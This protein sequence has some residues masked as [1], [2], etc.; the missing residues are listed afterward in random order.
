MKAEFAV[1]DLAAADAAADKVLAFAPTD[2]QALIFKGRIIVERARKSGSPADWKAARD[3]FRRAN[4]ADPDNAEALVLFYNGFVGAGETPP[5]VAM[6]G[7]LF[8]A[9]L[10]PRVPTLR[11]EAV[12]L[13]LRQNRLAEAVEMFRPVAFQPHSDEAS[14]ARAAQVLDAAN[15]GNPKEALRLLG[16]QR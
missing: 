7:L 9:D 10:V 6:K 1:R 14:R 8:A 13:L 3:W 11:I 15:A 4:A 2:V 12:K 16:D 5:D